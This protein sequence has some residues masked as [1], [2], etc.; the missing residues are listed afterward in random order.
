MARACRTICAMSAVSGLVALAVGC[1]APHKQAPAE[2]SK[3]AQSHPARHKSK[4]ELP[5]AVEKAFKDAFPQGQIEELEAEKENGVMV[6]D[7]E[8]R[9]GAAEEETD[10]AADGTVLEVTLVVEAKDVPPP[11]MQAIDK[12]AGGATLRRIEKIDIQYETEGGKVVKLAKP[13]THYAAEFVKGGRHTEVVVTPDGA[14][15]K[16]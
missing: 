5:P 13:V 8:F 10:I 6:Y 12:A 14:P 16:E 1:A 9:S 11:A 2:V 15:V 4:V 7:F 3:D